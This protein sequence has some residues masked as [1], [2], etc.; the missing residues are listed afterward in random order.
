M[1]RNKFIQSHPPLLRKKLYFQ[2]GKSVFFK[3]NKKIV[4]LLEKNQ[5]NSIFL[6]K[7]RTKIVFFWKIN[8]AVFSW[9]ENLKN[10]YFSR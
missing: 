9:R 2:Q 5:L 7:N 8:L 4:F 1:T 3:K 10:Q 6:E